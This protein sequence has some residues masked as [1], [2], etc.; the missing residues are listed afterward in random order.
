MKKFMIFGMLVILSALS[1][2]VGASTDFTTT[3]YNTY[4]VGLDGN[5]VRTATAYEGTFVLNRNFSSPEDIFIRDDIIYIADTGNAR[6][7]IYDPATRE[8]EEI[9]DPLMV[10]PTGIF[11]TEDGYI[12]VADSRALAVLVFD[13][14]HQL[15]DV[16]Y[17]PDEPLFGE[18]SVYQPTKIVVDKRGNIYVISEGGIYGIIQMNLEGDFLGYYGINEVN[19]SLQFLINRAL[20]SQE[21]RDMYAS[22]SPKSSTNLA[23]DQQGMIYTVIKNE[24][25]TSLKKLN[26]EGTNIL[27]ETQL[28]DPFYQDVT[29]D[30]YGNIYTVSGGL[31]VYNVVTV[32]DSFGHLLFMFGVQTV[33]SLK[34]GEFGLASGVAVDS[35]GDIWVL[36]SQGNNVQVFS[37]TEFAAKVMSAIELY[38]IGEYEDSLV[39]FEDIIR[40]NS[41]FALAHTRIGNIYEKQEEYDK[42]LESYTIA[43]NQ[44]GYSTAFWEV[45]DAWISQN[46]TI[47]MISL[48][49]LVVGFIVIRKTKLR[50]VFTNANLR[51]HSWFSKYPISTELKMMLRL[52]THP[53]DTIY[54]IKYK[55]KL[56]IRFAIGLYVVFVF[57]NIIS[58]YYIKGFLFRT[59]ANDLVFTYELLKWSIPILL[60]GVA[61]YLISTLQN[62]EAFFRDIFI[63]VILAFSPVFIMKVPLDILSNFLTYNETFLYNFGYLIMYGWSI[64]NLFIMIKEMNN[65]KFGE[66]IVNLL[67][68][69]FT[70]II[71]IVLYLVINILISQLFQFIVDIIKEVTLS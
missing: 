23:V 48:L 45:R 57:M 67:L 66:L 43:N 68:T 4:T 47:I 14:N 9:T 59:N 50:L 11:V 31:D 8:E 52:N 28:V 55:Q 27:T 2:Q 10:N 26:I 63:G 30:P 56:R 53:F 44:E 51:F 38:K 37:K 15:V 61:N 12:Y 39:L 18:D 6:I 40:Q 65:F 32:R 36:D 22:L 70:I 29:V 60:F 1:V 5:L 33:N 3:P 62:G 42:A 21:Q 19:I 49:V 46:M 71:F 64:I 7:Y 35:R 34:V 41:L 16:L 17:R 24:Y 69:I 20:M 58:N 25:V 13:D 54:D